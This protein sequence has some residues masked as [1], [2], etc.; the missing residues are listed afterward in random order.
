MEGV[1]SILKK[2]N[3]IL[4]IT[5]ILVAAVTFPL[6]TYIPHHEHIICYTG[7]EETIVLMYILSVTYKRVA[8]DILM[9]ILS[10]S[11]HGCQRIGMNYRYK[12]FAQS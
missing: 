8:Y 12:M 5:F 7:V 9:P 11:E 1:C 6:T 4:F 10:V 3:C 2:H